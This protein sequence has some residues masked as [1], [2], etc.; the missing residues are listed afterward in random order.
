MKDNHNVELFYL[1]I[2]EIT[3]QK[4]KKT[5][6]LQFHLHNSIFAFHFF[7]LKYLLGLGQCAVSSLISSNTPLQEIF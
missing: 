2:L 3:K 7:N 5:K 6:T 1:G 4:V